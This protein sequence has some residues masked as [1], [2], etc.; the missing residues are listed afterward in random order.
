MTANSKLA[1][2]THI[3]TILA[4]TPETVDPKDRRVCSEVIAHSVNTNP[5]VVRRIVSELAKAGLV[6]TYLGKGGGLVLGRP[7]DTITL[8]DVHEAIGND[9]LFAFKTHAPNPGCPTATRTVRALAPLFTSMEEGVRQQL[10]T[11]HLDELIRDVEGFELYSS[12][13]V[14]EA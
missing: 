1:V 5:V 14:I 11:I 7:P 10:A 13:A 8:L 3:L 9:S 12:E 4:L 6:S 2:A